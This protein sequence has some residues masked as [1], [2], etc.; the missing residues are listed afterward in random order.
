VS[1]RPLW[2]SKRQDLMRP[3]AVP[4]EIFTKKKDLEMSENP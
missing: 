1:H 4:L 3:D 2:G